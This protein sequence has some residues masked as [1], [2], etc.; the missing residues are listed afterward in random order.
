MKKL[1]T[2]TLLALSLQ[3]HGSLMKKEEPPP[4]DAD[5][6]QKNKQVI[7]GHAEFLYWRVQEGCL[8][9][10]LTMDT[11]AWGPTLN[12]AQ[13]TYQTQAWNGDPG[14]RVATSFFRAERLWEIKWEYT[15]MTARGSSQ[16]SKPQES[17]DYLTGTFPQIMSTLSS[18]NSSIH[19]NYNVFDMLIDRF[20]NPN[21]H[22]RLRLIAGG[23][24]AWINQ[25]WNV[26][27]SDFSNHTTSV[28]N[29]WA[30]IGGGFKSGFM[31]DWF[32]GYDYIYATLKM[33][34]G[35]YIGS[36]E[37]HSKQKTDYPQPNSN[38]GV[39]FKN[40][41]YQDIRPVFT[42]QI[43]IGP[44]WQKNTSH[45]RF[46]VFAGWECNGWL[47]IHEVYRSSFGSPSEPKETY[48]NNSL[49]AL[50]GLTTRFT[51]DF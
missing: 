50:Q 47:N 40:A 35:G 28:H 12:Y 36:Y 18:A 4:Y 23:S 45:N 24:A 22:L 42:F 43:Q 2:T 20:F 29:K 5:L 48:I 30:F 32:W 13:G 9:Y 46:E 11:Q 16:V 51:V 25:N 27:Y 49:I 44:S 34:A 17:L 15:R 39:P 37:N 26:H 41:T 21:P 31:V 3:A 10:A 14:F 8:D 1:L 19:M 33:L 38:P 7:S 6:F